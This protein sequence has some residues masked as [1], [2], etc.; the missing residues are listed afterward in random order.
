[1]GVNHEHIS[2]NDPAIFGAAMGKSLLT[3]TQ[4]HFSIEGT[5]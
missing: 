3:E 2:Q 4:E 5:T 1:M